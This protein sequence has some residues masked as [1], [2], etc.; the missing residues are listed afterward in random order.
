[1]PYWKN[2][3]PGATSGFRTSP[4]STAEFVATELAEA[5]V[6]LAV[7][8]SNAPMS[9]PPPAG[10][11]APRASVVGHTSAAPASIA[12]LPGFSATVWTGPPLFAGGASRGS[13]RVRSP[14]ARNLHW[15]RLSMLW[16]SEVSDPSRLQ[17]SAPRSLAPAATIVF[18]IVTEA[19]ASTKRSPPGWSSLRSRCSRRSSRSSA[20]GACSCR[21]A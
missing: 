19:P 15:S 20:T 17:F 16:P 7:A 2:A 8:T 18:S 12:G 21:R 14:V 9:Q 13:V 1:M 6:A 3:V 11:R 4:F 5:V 10:R